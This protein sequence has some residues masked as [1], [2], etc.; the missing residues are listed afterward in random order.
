MNNFY[1]PLMQNNINR[2]DANELIDFLKQEPLP[3]LTNGPKVREFEQKWSDWL[4]IKYSVFVNSGSSANQ[5][6]MLGLKNIYGGGEIIVPPL[7]WVSDIASV[8]QNGFTPV[9]CDIN[10]KNLSF[11]LE[12]LKK[13]I[14]PNTR[15]IFVT[16]VLGI[17]AVYYELLKLCE[18][19][20]IVLIEDVC[21]SH[22]ASYLGRKAGTFGFAS[23]FS[24]YFAHHMSTIEGGMIC[25][26]NERFYQWLRAFRSHG[27]VREMTDD[28]YKQE[29]ISQYPELNK[30]FVFI[31]PAYNFRST[32]LNAVLGL[33]Q[34]KKLDANNEKR[35]ANFK[36]F[37]DHLDGRR[38][39]TDINLDGQSNYAFIVILR[40]PSMEARD[41]VEKTLKAYLIE[42][43]RGLSGGGSQLKQPYLKDIIKEDKS[44]FPVMEHV[45]HYSWYIGNYPEL[46]R[47]KIDNLLRILNSISI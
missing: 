44:E 42:F 8:I 29:L 18:D 34:L 15:A 32:E 13:K 14:T 46:E 37:L 11:D 7:T 43:R 2:E 45:H 16:H 25:T 12:K 28:T 9:F 35:R 47:Y 10:F 21:E 20:D 31:A 33:S 39:V 22:G 23:N 6:T 41:L 1:L 5:L 36:Y 38:Y 30:D 3:Q 40:T 24:F 26:Q 17:N 4:G 27:M 19:H